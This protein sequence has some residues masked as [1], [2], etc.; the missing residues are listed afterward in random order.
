MI[1]FFRKI[2]KKMADDKKPLKYMRYA[3][4]EIVLVVIGILIALQINNWNEERKEYIEEKKILNNLNDE[5]RENFLNL[6]YKDSVLHTTI[7]NLETLFQEL[8]SPEK[9]F[10]GD[11]IDS[12]LSSALNSPTWIPSEYVLNGLKSSGNLIKLHNEQLKRLLF[13]WSRFYSEL[14]ETQ[15]MIE[16]TNS[17]LIKFIKDN[18]SLRNVDAENENFNY[19]KSLLIEHNEHLLNDPVFENYVDDKLYVLNTAKKQFKEAELRIKSILE[20]TQY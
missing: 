4:G 17:Q 10:N 16:T 2:R 20:A 15:R 1:P 12:I 6:K 11:S 7:L 14:D 3:I 13:E 9:N 19:G 8:R 5:F 18:G